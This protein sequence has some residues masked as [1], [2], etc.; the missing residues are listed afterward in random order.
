ML[1]D[2][3]SD[4]FAGK[5]RRDGRFVLL[6]AAARFV[7]RH[8]FK[9]LAVGVIT[10]LGR[11][12][13]LDAFGEIGSAGTIALEVV[14]EVPRVLLF[15]AAFGDGRIADGARMI[16]CGFA[17]K[18]DSSAAR[19][20]DECSSL[21]REVGWGCGAY[22]LLALL[23]NGVVAW[24]VRSSGVVESINQLD[25]HLSLSSTTLTLIL[26]NLTIISFTAVFIA[27]VTKRFLMPEDASRA[28]NRRC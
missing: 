11:A 14:V 19:R 8:P 25:P 26:K 23:C 4:L 24:I 27:I 10:A 17:K 18:T 20:P 13:Q 22:L 2:H 3:P 12:A 16:R 5:V 9:F 15:L 6:V 1:A 21:W 28:A 7:G